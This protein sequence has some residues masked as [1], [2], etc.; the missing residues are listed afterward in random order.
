MTAYLKF[1][2]LLVVSAF[3]IISLHSQ[4]TLNCPPTTGQM[5][6]VNDVTPILTLD[7]FLAEGGS[8]SS[9]SAIDSNS[10]SVVS[11]TLSGPLCSQ[12]YTRMFQ[13]SDIL[14]NSDTCSQNI[15][16]GDLSSPVLQFDFTFLNCGDPLPPVIQTY[17]QLLQVAVQVSDNCALDTS[18][19]HYVKDS[20][21]VQYCP[22]TLLRIYA[23]SDSCGNT[24]S[25]NQKFIFND[26]SP[27]TF[28]TPADITLYVDGMCHYDISTVFTGDVTDEADN[29]S[30]PDSLQAV[31]SDTK[32]SGCIDGVNGVNTIIQRLWTLTDLCGLSTQHTQIIT[33]IDTISPEFTPP[34]DVTIYADAQCM[35]DT[36]LNNTGDVVDERDNCNTNL[37]ATYKDIFHPAGCNGTGFITRLWSLKDSCSNEKIDSQKITLLDTLPPG[38]IV[39]K[40]TIVNCLTDTGVVNIGVPDVS[41]LCDDSIR[42]EHKDSIILG[43]GCPYLYEIERTWTVI[44]GCGNASNRQQIIRV[45][46]TLSP[47]SICKDTTLYVDA[48][49]IVPGLSAND[50]DNGS[51][52]A[53]TSL[54]SLSISRTAFTCGDVGVVNDTLIAVDSCLNRDT[55]IAHVTILDTIPPIV[56]CSDTVLKVFNTCAV[57][58]TFNVPRVSDNCCL[59]DTVRMDLTGLNTGDTFPVGITTI[60]YRFWDCHNNYTDCQFN[61]E[62]HPASDTVPNLACNDLVQVSLDSTCSAQITPDIILEG[63]VTTCNNVFKIELFVHELKNENLIPESPYVNGNYIGDT[64]V[65][66][67]VNVFTGNS[68]WGKIKVEDKFIPA[69]KCHT[70]TLR[71]ARS[72][73]PDSLGY[74]VPGTA[75]VEATVREREYVVHGFDSCGDVKLWYN[76]ELLQDF[77]CDLA[78]KVMVRK[79]TAEDGSGNRSMCVD[80]I[81]IH[82]PNLRQDTIGLHDLTF[83]CNGTWSKLPNGYPSPDATGWPVPAGCTTL[84]ATYSDQRLDVCGATYKV[85]RHW[86]VVD[87]CVGNGVINDNYPKILDF[88]QVIKVVDHDPPSVYCASTSN[89]VDTIGM[90]YY[91]CSGTYHLPV[92]EDLED[93]LTIPDPYGV[94]VIGECSEWTYR[95]RHVASKSP[96]DCTPSDSYGTYLGAARTKDD[97]GFVKSGLPAGCNWF[98]YEITD[99]C[100]NTSSCAFDIYVK[101]DQ[102][103]IAVCEGHT[104]VTLNLDGRAKVYARSLDDGSIDNCMIDTMLVRRMDYGAPCQTPDKTFKSYVEFC[105]ADA[106]QRIMVEFKVIDKMGNASVC[107]VEV[108]VVDK[109]APKVIPLPDL[110]VNCRYKYDTSDLSSYFGKI[111][112]EAGLREEIEIGGRVVGRDGLATDNCEVTR[113]E[114]TAKINLH[115]HKGWI[116]RTFKIYDKQ[117]LLTISKQHISLVDPVPFNSKGRDIRWPRDILDRPLVTNCKKGVNTDPAVTG[118]P[119]YSNTDCAHVTETYTDKIYHSVKDACYKI[120][121]TWTVIDWCQYAKAGDP[122]WEHKQYIKVSNYTAPEFAAESCEDKVFCDSSAYD[123]KGRCIGHAKLKP[124]AHDDCTPDDELQWRYRLDLGVTGT[125]GPWRNSEDAS[126]T[127][128][129]GVHKIEWSV[130][131]G[132]GNET[133]CSYEF[134]VKDCKKPT[135]YCRDEIV[136]VIMPTSGEIEIWASDFNIGS[137]DNCTVKEDLRYS[138]TEDGKTPNKTFYCS[139]LEGNA[140]KEIPLT[141]W[142]LDEAGNAEG[143]S[144]LLKLQDNG[145][146]KSGGQLARISGALMKVTDTPTAIGDVTLYRETGEEVKALEGVQGT[147]KIEDVKR[148][149]GYELKVRYEKDYGKGVSTRDL[150]AIQK[151][152]LGK[153]DLPAPWQRIAAD[154][155]NSG[156][157]STADILALRKIIL[158]KSQKLKKSGSWRYYPVGMDMS[159][160]AAMPGKE[161]HMRIP[162]VNTDMDQMNFYGI[163]IGDV[164]GEENMQ[165]GG[166]LVKGGEIT[167]K[168]EWTEGADDTRVLSVRGDGQE[169]LTA[170]QFTI[171]YP[172]NMTLKK[173]SQGALQGVEMEYA[174]YEGRTTVSWYSTEPTVEGELIRFVFEG[175]ISEGDRAEVQLGS[176][177]TANEVLTESGVT[178]VAK[179]DLSTEVT[180][181]RDEAQEGYQLLQNIPN[182]FKGTTIIPFTLPRAQEVQ[183]TFRDISGKVL[184]RRTLSGQKGYNT[185]EVSDRELG[186]NKGVVIYEMRANAFNVVKKMMLFRQ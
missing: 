17:N 128:E 148:N 9:M 67:I 80:T 59:F 110:T 95:V 82:L 92:P 122:I 115:C 1:L 125:Y 3:F 105:C 34:A 133:R 146:C 100:G 103:P 176:E 71:C 164:T 61:I 131:D 171:S 70:D 166:N 77:D 49:G 132:C 31:F 58:V 93:A 135:P 174:I 107:M 104:V 149:E 144:V 7:E 72:I 22:H 55:C 36:S 101:D 38:F 124:E 121:R 158:G 41:M 86:K 134:E 175:T 33:I 39:P 27:P 19:F 96:Q 119:R 40:D 47:V 147:Y 142:V 173:V 137:S 136:T 161:D 113:I 65:V 54:S 2:W 109:E 118:K 114:E 44:D 30:P 98:Y 87:W 127:Y 151:Y 138:F 155:N 74:P 73:S 23:I 139:D 60:K 66:K 169:A 68:C 21:V 12:W 18:T 20:I 183:F 181:T 50:L 78:Y 185:L 25:A 52:D 170:L 153:G 46:D 117:G 28:T 84:V 62:I 165:T 179:L 15:S 154:A 14:G 180:A 94:Y 126:G 129:T 162:V 152:L 172:E 145:D 43:G 157:I 13:L 76:D 57:P 63:D 99:A 184:F 140:S 51:Y 35:Y 108:E 6:S 186:L 141:M 168:G 90:D 10:F 111:V 160:L 4:V 156:S 8:V 91:K 182:P 112:K 29:C 64:L 24:A 26:N 11:E 5:C 163:K 116:E 150:V 79:W 42:V 56:I 37:E 120:E 53:C 143:C 167:L 178:G 97:P 88:Y 123:Y 130:T 48:N 89:M 45:I 85:L 81:R 102:L 69:L 159:E 75:T 83:S 106:G 177:I 16:I 32:I